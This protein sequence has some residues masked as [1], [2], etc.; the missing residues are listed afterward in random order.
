MYVCIVPIVH[1]VAFTIA[2]GC[3]LESGVGLS[4]TVG[5]WIDLVDPM[6]LKRQRQTSKTP[7]KF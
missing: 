2:L 1:N 4:P 5:Y 6:Q 3:D 7:I